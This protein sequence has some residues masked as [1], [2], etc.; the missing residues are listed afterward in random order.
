MISSV[1]SDTLPPQNLYDTDFDEASIALPASRPQSDLTPVTYSI[2]KG[3]LCKISG[4]IST[5]ANRIQLPIYA[6]ILG[7]DQQILLAYSNIPP[8][9]LQT[10][11]I[12][13]IDPPELIIKRLSLSLVFNKS[14]CML[15]RRFLTEPRG[16]GDFDFSK[17]IAINSSMEVL[18]LQVL[19]HEAFLPGGPLCQDRWFLS[20]LSMYD[21]LV[22]G[23]IVYL[24]LIQSLEQGSPH[25]SPSIL[26]DQQQ[27]RINMLKQSYEIWTHT[28]NMS[29][30]MK[31]ASR[32]IAA[33]LQNLSLR[34]SKVSGIA[35]VSSRHGSHTKDITIPTPNDSELGN[36]FPSLLVTNLNP[37]YY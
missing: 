37:N 30:E 2:M 1:D 28:D 8:F 32:L 6:D 4:K 13:I 36:T 35:T 15:H 31:R 29:V 10:S 25:N 18:Q 9:F 23:M 21:F 20:A 22:S 14:R 26:N 24:S 5:L 12:S 16:S 33:L 27:R 34:D 11:S 19:V 7:L 3:T 17:D